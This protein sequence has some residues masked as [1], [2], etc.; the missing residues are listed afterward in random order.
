M[1]INYSSRIKKYSNKIVTHIFGYFAG[2][3][4]TPPLQVGVTNYPHINY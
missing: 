1:L 4:C 2:L 3:L